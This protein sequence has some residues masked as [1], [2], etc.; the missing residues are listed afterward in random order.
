MDVNRDDRVSPKKFHRGMISVFVTGDRFEA[1]FRPLAMAVATLCDTDGD[2]Q[3][4]QDEFRAMQD[5]FGTVPTDTDAAFTA[6]DTDKSGTITVDEYLVA[7]RQ[8]YTSDDP[9]APGNW[10]YGKI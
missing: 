10:L 7:V 8:Y 2:G 5:S 6:L 9:E 1:V 3:I 4:N